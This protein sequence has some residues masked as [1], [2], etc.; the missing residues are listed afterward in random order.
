[1]PGC[2]LV[3]KVKFCRALQD[4]D[5]EGIRLLWQC[6][7]SVTLTCST[8]TDPALLLQRSLQA[9]EDYQSAAELTDTWAHW[10][11]KVNSLLSTLPSKKPAEQEKFLKAKDISFKGAP[12]SRALVNAVAA[13]KRYFCSELARADQDR[14]EIFYLFGWLHQA[15]T[16]EPDRSVLA[17]RCFSAAY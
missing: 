1:M 4:D 3:L 2:F 8:S 6:G 7:R 14:Q 15:N 11:T 17:P 13:M 10:A 16:F 12:S 5:M 9:S